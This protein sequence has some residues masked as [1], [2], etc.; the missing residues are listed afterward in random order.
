MASVNIT[1]GHDSAISA[2]L[3]NR[4]VDIVGDVD[5]F[6]VDVWGT[7]PRSFQCQAGPRLLSQAEIWDM[8]D[9]GLL[10]A[11]YF[12]VFREDVRSA[13]ADI[14]ETRN[15]LN[16]PMAAYADAAA[17]RERFASGHTFKLNQP[18]HWHAGIKELLNGLRADFRAE[19]RSSVFLSPPDATGVQAHTDEAH[20]LV[21][22]L[23]GHMD[24]CVG[25]SPSNDV[26]EGQRVEA[27]LQ[28][29]DVLYIPSGHPHYA[30]ARGGD[31]LHIAI[32]VQQPSARDLAELA[33]AGFLDGPRANKIA[34]T[35]HL[36]S[37]DEKV[38]WLRVELAEQL[39]GQDFG[40]LVD[41][42]V[43]IRQRGGQV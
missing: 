27:T 29:G 24:W 39:S 42:A 10:V 17:V 15:V 23:D 3:P 31:S 30:T 28:P 6:F 35:H 20:A 22:Q 40:A 16:R 34:G 18:E 9:C 2:G 41:E 14:T 43:R 11:P 37:I 26:D 5:S 19:V 32:T 13:V 7:R 33:L 8:L 1:H 4:L 21:L 25:L 12:S 38:A 36:M